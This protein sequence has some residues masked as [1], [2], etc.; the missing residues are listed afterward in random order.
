MALVYSLRFRRCTGDAARIGLG[1]RR[2]IELAFERRRD[3]AIGRGIGPRPARRRHLAGAKLRDDLFPL[4]PHGRRRGSTSRRVELQPGRFQPAVVAGD[5]VLVERVED[6]ARGDRRRGRTGCRCR[7]LQGPGVHVTGTGQTR[8]DSANSAG[9]ARERTDP[10]GISD[11]AHRSL[12]HA[13]RRRRH[14]LK[15]AL[16]GHPNALENARR[17]PGEGHHE[18]EKPSATD[19]HS[20]RRVHRGGRWAKAQHRLAAVARTQP[21]RHARPRSPS[22]RRG[23]IS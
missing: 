6:V 13:G 23:P 2:R 17:G 22:R 4:L 8:A 12:A 10:C 1:R 21:G 15:Y 3:R 11:L 7:A 19:N 9:S 18:T 5:A 16:P 14:R 20:R